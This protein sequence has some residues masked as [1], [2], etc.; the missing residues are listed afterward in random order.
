MFPLYSFA[1]SIIWKPL[2]VERLVFYELV[3]VRRLCAERCRGTGSST[4]SSALPLAAVALCPGRGHHIL[5]SRSPLCLL[6]DGKSSEK[7]FV[8]HRFVTWPAVCLAPLAARRSVTLK[9]SQDRRRSDYWWR[10]DLREKSDLTE[11][12]AGAI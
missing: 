4:R 11:S 9:D 1:F 3:S 7:K 6:S 10:R 12:A 8:S 5:S 2:L